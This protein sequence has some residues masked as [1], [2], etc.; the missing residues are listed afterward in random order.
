MSRLLLILALILPFVQQD[1]SQVSQVRLSPADMPP[2]PFPSFGGFLRYHG[3]EGQVTF[4]VGFDDEGLVASVTL[5]SARL[6]FREIEENRLMKILLDNWE[7]VLK[8]WR[9]GAIP[10][11]E[12]VFTV[13]YRID[14]TL[15]E[16]QRAFFVEYGREGYPIFLRL[17]A[18]PD[19]DYTAREGRSPD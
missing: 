13:E 15:T 19:P 9:W 1:E 12:Q 3:V 17:V 11:P 8:E 2:P 18:P 16:S 6:R 5:E 14:T 10:L 7:R 4:R